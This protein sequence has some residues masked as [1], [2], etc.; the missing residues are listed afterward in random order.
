MKG[1]IL[2]Y[3]I[4]QL[5]RYI[6]SP[7]PHIERKRKNLLDFDWLIFQLWWVLDHNV[8]IVDAAKVNLMLSEFLKIIRQLFDPK[9]YIFIEKIGVIYHICQFRHQGLQNCLKILNIVL[10]AGLHKFWVRRKISPPFTPLS[11]F[12]SN[13]TTNLG[14]WP[15]FESILLSEIIYCSFDN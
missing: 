11:N 1:E 4:Q 9:K 13:N 15:S 6:T 5:G 8:C 3:K 2:F 12:F 7:T 10:I 14:K